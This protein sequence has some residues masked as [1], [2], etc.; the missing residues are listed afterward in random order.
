VSELVLK[1]QLTS[2]FLDEP[3]IIRA[4][5]AKVDFG[6][7]TGPSVALCLKVTTASPDRLLKRIANVFAQ[8]FSGENLD[9]LFLTDEQEEGIRPVCQTFFSRDRTR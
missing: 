5:L 1:R 9:V 7:E 2:E 8:L 3:T 4:Y 6:P